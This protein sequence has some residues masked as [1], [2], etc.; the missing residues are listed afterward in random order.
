VKIPG[1]MVAVLGDGYVGANTVRVD[2]K[3]DSMLYAQVR[4]ADLSGPVQLVRFDSELGFGDGSGQRWV[5]LTGRYMIDVYRFKRD[6][7]H[8]YA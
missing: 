3:W 7:Q 4:E 6:S 2:S 8:E 1:Q 5:L